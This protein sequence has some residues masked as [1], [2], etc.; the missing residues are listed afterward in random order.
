VDALDTWCKE[1]KLN[2]N[3]SKCNCITF[4]NKRKNVI[5]FDY[6]INNVK[7]ER[8]N[9]IRDLGVILTSE[10][11]YTKHITTITPKAFRLLGF[12]RRNF[13][14]A[15]SPSTFKRLYLMLVRP[16][17]DYASVV[18]NP[19]HITMNQHLEKIQRRFVRYHCWRTNIVYHGSDYEHLC[20]SIGIMTLQRR[21][22]LTDLI[23]FYKIINSTFDTELLQYINFRVP[24]RTTRDHKPFL[25]AR[26]RI[27][28]FK[29]SAICRM[30]VEFNNFSAN[31]DTIMDFKTFKIIASN[32]VKCY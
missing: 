5:N 11:S 12:I 7:L 17:V 15:F 22:V 26:S 19:H 4:T 9:Y 29:F 24:S 18:W 27:D 10:L 16:Q 2:L 8:V 13:H 23:C 32:Q 14:S 1:W 20:E 6:S 31:L 30:Q 28:V 25:P 3:V 21:R